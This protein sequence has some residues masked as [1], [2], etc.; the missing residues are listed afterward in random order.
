[1]ATSVN[2]ETFPVV[3]Y[4]KLN[5]VFK[6]IIIVNSKQS[7]SHP[8][9]HSFFRPF[10]FFG[11]IILASRPF[12]LLSLPFGV[13]SLKLPSLA[14]VCH[15]INIKSTRPKRSQLLANATGVDGMITIFCDVCQFSAKKLAF[16]LNTNVMLKIFEKLTTGDICCVVHA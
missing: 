5:V 12:G 3:N 4:R 6:L 14:T 9:V 2:F 7:S 10:I 13:G 8:A 15:N 16:F 11:R 1:L